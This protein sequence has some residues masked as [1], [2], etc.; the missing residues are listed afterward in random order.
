MTYKTTTS[1]FLLCELANTNAGKQL[2]C[3][4]VEHLSSLY[5]LTSYCF[6]SAAANEVSK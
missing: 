2:S 4:H 3:N 1:Y 5:R 6:P